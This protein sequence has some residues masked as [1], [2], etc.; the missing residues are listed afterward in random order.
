MARSE[1][2]ELPTLGFEVRGSSRARFRRFFHFGDVRILLASGRKG[3]AAKDGWPPGGHSIFGGSRRS[4][5]YQADSRIRKMGNS[6]PK[7]PAAKASQIMKCRPLNRH[8]P[9]VS[10]LDGRKRRRSTNL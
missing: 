9:T 7:R 6:A 4:T 2:F 3:E 10:R 8:L 1:R 5:G